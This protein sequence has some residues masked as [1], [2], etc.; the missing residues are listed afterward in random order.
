MIKI[1]GAPVGQGEYEVLLLIVDT[2]RGS[3]ID[4]ARGSRTG[5]REFGSQLSQIND[6]ENLYL[7]PLSLELT[8]LEYGKDWLAQC[9]VSL[10]QDNVIEWDILSRCQQP[11]FP[12]GQ[13]YEVIM[14]APYHKSVVI[15]I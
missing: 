2:G 12:V 5:D 7:S 11:D 1:L 10:S 15:L 14:S 6:L 3:R 9:L 8:L 4:R 13:H